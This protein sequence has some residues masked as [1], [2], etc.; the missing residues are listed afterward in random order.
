[1]LK[2]F[3]KTPPQVM[4][5]VIANVQNAFPKDARITDEMWANTM[6]FNMQA[7]KIATSLD[8]REGV[9]W[10]NAFNPAR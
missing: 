4:K 3:D 5:A 9:L 10:T 2:F 6:R 8:S 1:M 7:G